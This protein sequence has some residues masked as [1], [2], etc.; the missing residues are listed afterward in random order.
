[1]FVIDNSL[2]ALANIKLLLLHLLTI[3]CK[4]DRVENNKA[5]K[6]LRDCPRHMR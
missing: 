6:E 3:E 5:Y 1:M 2:E 4:V